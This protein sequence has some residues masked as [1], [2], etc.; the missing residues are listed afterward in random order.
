MANAALHR[1]GARTAPSSLVPPGWHWV[2]AI[3]VPVWIV[4]LLGLSVAC[5]RLV[6]DATP[7][8][9]TG[10][11][12]VVTLIGYCLVYEPSFGRSAETGLVG[13]VLCA[14]LALWIGIRTRNVSMLAAVVSWVVALW[15]SIATAY[16]IQVL[17]L[18]GLDP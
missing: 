5:W 17:R 15:S 13:N 4:L 3:V 18:R 9:H 11:W 7:E 14:V 8:A 16:L 1:N 10:A 6:R 2:D 12:F